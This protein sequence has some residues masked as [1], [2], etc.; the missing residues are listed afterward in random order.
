MAAKQY[1]FN[2]QTLSY[3]VVPEPFRL[4]VYRLLRRLLIGFIGVCVVNIVFSLF[5]YTP[6]LSGLERERER[7]LEGYAMLTGRTKA[8][9]NRLEM[10]THRDNSVYRPLFAADTLSVEGIQTPYPADRYAYLAGDDYADVITASWQEADRLGRL[11]YRQSISLDQLQALSRDKELMA[12]AIP[13]IWP[14]DRRNL[15]GGIGSFG[16]RMH[17]IYQRLIT[18]KGI[19]LGAHTGDSVYATGNGIVRSID[20]G[21]PRVGYGRQILVDHGFGYQTRY[22]HLSRILVSPGQHVQRGELIGLVGSSGGSTGPHLHYEVIYTGN[23][24]NPINYFRRDMDEA[25]FERIIRNARETTF[26]TEPAD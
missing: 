16:R 5:F 10:I 4:R 3:E 11:L 23:V 26:E 21:M 12:T 14:I 18:H 24:V 2:P 19:D 6:K 7:L 9:E 8:M 20:H 15:R 17:P 25:E 13:A 22:A 1:K